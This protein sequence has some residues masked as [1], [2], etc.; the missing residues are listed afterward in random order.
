MDFVITINLK[1]F[2]RLGYE[3]WHTGKDDWACT[4]SHFSRSS[5]IDV[6]TH[7]LSISMREGEGEEEEEE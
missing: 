2:D 1:W 5:L 4:E 7:N 3:H 6:T